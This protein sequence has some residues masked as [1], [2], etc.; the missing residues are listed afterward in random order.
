V[1]LVEPSLPAKQARVHQQ[2]ERSLRVF[3]VPVRPHPDL[4]ADPESVQQIS[5]EY[6]VLAVVEGP[7][8]G[9]TL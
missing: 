8:D 9:R 5:G 6:G 1:R 2:A 7:A 4:V 3:G